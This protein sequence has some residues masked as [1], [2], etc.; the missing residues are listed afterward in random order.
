MIVIFFNVFIFS[1]FLMTKYFYCHYFWLICTS[2][3]QCTWHNSNSLDS[4]LNGERQ[5][6][7]FNM[8]MQSDRRLKWSRYWTA[9][10]AYSGKDV[11]QNCHKNKL[12]DIYIHTCISYN[13]CTMRW[14]LT[15]AAKCKAILL[16]VVVPSRFP[17]S[18][19]P[20][21]PPAQ[22]NVRVEWSPRSSDRWRYFAIL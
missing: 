11:Y 21:A 22:F 6:G 7:H 20:L 5:L 14:Q 10:G 19:C 18:A 13:I 17:T 15:P 12:P 16:I 3:F 2:F 1:N 9:F 8:H 4:Q